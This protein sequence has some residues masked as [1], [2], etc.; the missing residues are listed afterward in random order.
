MAQEQII[1]NGLK[2]WEQVQSTRQ[3]GPDSGSDGTEPQL[4]DIYP[5]LYLAMREYNERIYQERQAHFDSTS[6]CRETVIDITQYGLE[7]GPVGKIVIPDIDV[8]MALYL[9][10]S[11]ENLAKGVAQLGQTSLPIGGVNTNCVISGHRGWKGA[12]Y[13]RDIHLLEMGDVLYLETIWGTLEYRV[14]RQPL[15]IEPHETE[16]LL[17]QPG[18]DMLTVVTCEPY[19]VGTHRYVVYFERYI[20][21]VPEN[22]TEYATVSP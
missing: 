2:D 1:H 18:K 16:N 3:P 12:A 14:S 7:D 19:G 4:P 8:E 22:E 11:D 15:V 13:L 9:G 20:E 6:A 17:I 21:E 10:A 5:E